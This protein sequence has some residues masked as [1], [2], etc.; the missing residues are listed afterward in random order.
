MWRRRVECLTALHLGTGVFGEA[1][2]EDDDEDEDGGGG[3]RV[4]SDAV[5]PDSETVNER[6]ERKAEF[7][8]ERGLFDVDSSEKRLSST[9]GLR[10][11]DSLSGASGLSAGSS[12][13]AL[14]S[15]GRK[16]LSDLFGYRS[17][18]VLD[19]NLA[20]RI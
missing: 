5:N 6:F 19:F 20:W 11:L 16:Q 18:Y 2:E 10:T 8:C 14:V 3:G 12:A 4:L 7:A 15:Y 17:R 13:R 9:S 1:D